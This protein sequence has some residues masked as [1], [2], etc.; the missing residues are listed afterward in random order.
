MLRFDPMTKPSTLRLADNSVVL[1][2]EGNNLASPI[3]SL[4]AHPKGIKA[5]KNH[6][7]ISRM[8]HMTIKD[9]AASMSKMASLHTK[10]A[11]VLVYKQ[12]AENQA[13]IADLWKLHSYYQSS[14]NESKMKKAMDKIDWRIGLDE[15]IENK[16]VEK[17]DGEDIKNKE[18]DLLEGEDIEKKEVELLDGENSSDEINDN[19]EMNDDK[20]YND[21]EE[22]SSDD[23][24]G[25]IEDDDNDHDNKNQESD[26]TSDEDKVDDDKVVNDN[27]NKDSDVFLMFEI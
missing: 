11:A 6:V 10:I 4:F 19:N 25:N 7:K 13:K 1:K 24:D 3:G 26:R 5:A 15:D 9:F 17:L 8:K 23:V 18:A 16:E 12:F 21:K 20:D 27:E 2:G 22:D 14:N